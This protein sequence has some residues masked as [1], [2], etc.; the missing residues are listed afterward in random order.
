MSDFI[1]EDCPDCVDPCLWRF[2]IALNDE[3]T[4]GKRQVSDEEK[5]RRGIGL[6]VWRQPWR[7]DG[8]K[9]GGTALIGP[10]CFVWSWFD[11][12]APHKWGF[13]RCSHPLIFAVWGRWLHIF[14]SHRESNEARGNRIAVD[15]EM[16]L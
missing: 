5:L 4:M 2:A 11:H 14:V 10:L 6:A 1:L 7:S 9:M 16:S 15:R 3:P 8:K 13:R 12:C